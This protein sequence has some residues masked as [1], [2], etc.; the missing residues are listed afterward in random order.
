[1]NKLTSGDKAIYFCLPDDSG[2]DVCLKDF[3]G[4]WVVL[5]FYPKDNTSGCTLE[6]VDF[7]RKLDE[8]EK[9]NAVIIGVSPDSPKSHCGFREKH[10]LKI[11]LLSDTDHG[12]IEKYGAWVLKKMIGR[13]YFGVERSTFLIN[14][15][16][17]IASVWRKVKVKEHVN[18]V[19]E[20]LIELQ[21]E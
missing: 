12:V 10:D 8:F 9:R 14:P 2:K 4:R 1:M 20:K 21:S 15:N 11:T 6:A 13:E 17:G 5:Y 18:N 7:S 19:L 16:G 3:A